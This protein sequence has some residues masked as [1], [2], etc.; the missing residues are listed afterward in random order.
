MGT[1][2]YLSAAAAV[3][4]A[5]GMTLTACAPQPVAPQTALN[6]ATTL[7]VMWNQAMFSLN[8]ETTSGN[9]TTNA[10][11]LYMIRD[12]WLYYDKDLNMIPDKGYGTYEKV[13]DDPLTIKATFA[14]GA[15]WSDGVALSAADFILSYGAE[16]TLYNTVEDAY[17]AGLMN[18]DGTVKPNK[19]GQVYFDANINGLPLI[20]DFPQVSDDGKSV[21][22]VYSKPF[23]DWEQTMTDLGGGLPAHIVAKRALGVS[24]PAQANQALID[25]FKNNDKSAL[26]KIANVWNSDFNFTKMP[27]DTD[28]VLSCGPYVITDYQENQYV[29]LSTND[30]YKGAHKAPFD[31]ITVRYNGDPMANV[32][33]LQNDEVQLISPQPTADIL[34]ALEGQENTIGVISGDEATYEHVDLTFNN[35]GP[36]D[37]KKYG[38]DAD[39]AKLVR[40]AFLLTVPRQTIVD[41]I[42]KPL[43]PNAVVRNSFNVIPGAPNYDDTVAANGM[44]TV[45][46]QTDTDKAKSLLAQAGVSKPKVRIMYDVKNTRRQQ[47][48]ALMKESAEKAGFQIVDSGNANWGQKLGDGTYDA[49]LFGWQSQSTA[50][51]E[52]AANYITKGANNFGGYSNKQIDTLYDQLNTETDP[53]QQKAINEQVEKIL[54]DDAFSITIFQFPSVTAFSK[55]LSGVDPITI[56]PTIFWNYWDW[57]LGAATT[58]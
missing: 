23:A 31:T 21:T 49:S 2:R 3:L 52:P 25:A 29:T 4:L 14:D 47:E 39:K 36:F 57:K 27:S 40:Q 35:N 55:T 11:I 17:D 9:A 56:S 54:V 42:I 22:I 13:S 41:N 50:V 48:F 5:G 46:A 6:Q 10:N 43:N 38:G 32:Q 51:S 19:D 20:K 7:S 15:Q 30:K 8:R 26:S 24:D 1:K 12:N 33:A 28:L 53:A 16:S 58:K 45:Y 37:P 34:K 18:D 44:A